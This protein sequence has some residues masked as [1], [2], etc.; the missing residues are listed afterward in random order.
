MRRSARMSDPKNRA[1]AKRWLK[2][3][4]AND[5]TI[6]PSVTRARMKILCSQPEAQHGGYRIEGQKKGD[7]WI[8]P[9]TATRAGLPM[10]PCSRFRTLRAP[11]AKAVGDVARYIDEALAETRS[12]VQPLMRV[13]SEEEIRLRCLL[14][15]LL[16]RL[17]DMQATPPAPASG[18]LTA[19]SG[20]L[21]GPRLRSSN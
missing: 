13:P 1:R 9:V 5:S 18:S 12:Q 14:E 10:L 21:G 2:T 16:K 11:W 19:S 20:P 7:G 3:V 4:E 17:R 6:K 15:A 8:L